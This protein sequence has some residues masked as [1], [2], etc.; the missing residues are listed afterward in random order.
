MKI[1]LFLIVIKQFLCI[2]YN[3]F[4]AS[5]K[6]IPHPDKVAKGGEDAFWDS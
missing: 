6:N 4:E 5:Y 3:Y 2:T 1:L